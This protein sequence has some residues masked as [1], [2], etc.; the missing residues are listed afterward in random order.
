MILVGIGTKDTTYELDWLA[1]KLLNARLFPDSAE[2]SW[3]WKRNVMEIEAEVLCVSQFTLCANVRK[4]NK[5]DFHGALV[6]AQKRLLAAHECSP[7]CTG[8][9]D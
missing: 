1:G 7:L 6:S 4:G 3:G 9:R 8:C 5:P 2:E